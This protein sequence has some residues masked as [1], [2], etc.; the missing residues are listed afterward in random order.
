MPTT[1]TETRLNHGAAALAAMLS[2]TRTSAV[3]VPGAPSQAGPAR[4]AHGSGT[5]GIDTKETVAPYRDARPASRRWNRYP[6]VTRP[7]SPTVR[8]VTRVRVIHVAP[9]GFGPDGLF[10]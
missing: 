5:L 3:R 8:S 9:T 7:G 2:S 6:P 4:I 10:G 1:G